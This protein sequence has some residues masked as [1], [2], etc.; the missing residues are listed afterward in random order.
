[1]TGG[2]NSSLTSKPS[3]HVLMNRAEKAE[4]LDRLR[5]R[6]LAISVLRSELALME[7][8]LAAARDSLRCERAATA[9]ASQRCAQQAA[10][11]SESAAAAA[12]SLEDAQAATETANASLAEAQVAA[13][14]RTKAYGLL[15]ASQAERTRLDDALYECTVLPLP[16]VCAAPHVCSS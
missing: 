5:M 1:M 4:L 13:D 9:L 12:A 3:M 15:E 14:E 7:S 8:E 16:G 11:A 6:K 10:L 2:N